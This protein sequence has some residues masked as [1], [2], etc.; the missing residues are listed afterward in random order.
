[1]PIKKH[2]TLQEMERDFGPLTFGK[3]LAAYR[4]AEEMTAK[5]FSKMLG[6]TPQ[7]LCDLEKG[8]KL[9]SVGRAAKIARKLGEPVE[10]WISLA[11]EDQVRQAD[12]RYRVE[13]RRVS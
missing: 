8:R 13:L 11:L 3:T 10:S 5:E 4:Q 7:S 9:P 6:M 12:L 1:M 2:Y